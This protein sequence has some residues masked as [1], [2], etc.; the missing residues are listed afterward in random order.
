MF[1]GN[2]WGWKCLPVFKEMGILSAE[3]FALRALTAGY[4]KRMS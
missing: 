2:A 1:F 4:P 3:F